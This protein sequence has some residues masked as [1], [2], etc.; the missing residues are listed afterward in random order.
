MHIIVFVGAFRVEAQPARP[1]VA[2]N[3]YNVLNNAHHLLICGMVL[4]ACLE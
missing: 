4:P 3:T 2:I 1:A